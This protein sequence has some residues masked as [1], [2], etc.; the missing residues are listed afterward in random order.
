MSDMSAKIDSILQFYYVNG[1]TT[2]WVRRNTCVLF[3][4]KM[5]YRK[6]QSNYGSY[7]F[8][9]EISI[10]KMPLMVEQRRKSF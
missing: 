9:P 3:V 7:A 6:K 2:D 10:W 4:V 5:R 8:F 1:T